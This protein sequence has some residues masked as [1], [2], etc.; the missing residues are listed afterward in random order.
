METPATPVQALAES[1]SAEALQAKS[2]AAE[3][4]A[5]ARKADLAAAGEAAIDAYMRRVGTMKPGVIFNDEQKAEIKNI[6]HEAL[7]EFFKTYS[8]IGKNAFLVIVSLITGIVSFGIATKVFL[9][10]LGFTYIR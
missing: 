10:W 6:F 1:A 7:G 3:A 4:E 2:V 8:T 9:G 5:N